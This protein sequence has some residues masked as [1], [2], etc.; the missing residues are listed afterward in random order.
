MLYALPNF[1]A[2][3]QDV[4]VCTVEPA[5]KSPYIQVTLMSGQILFNTIE[6]VT[7]KATLVTERLL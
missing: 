4:S 6:S 3:I 2:D 7:E 1:L 5:Y